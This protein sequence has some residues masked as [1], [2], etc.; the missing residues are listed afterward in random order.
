MVCIEDEPSDLPCQARTAEWDTKQDGF[1]WSLERHLDFGNS[2]AFGMSCTHRSN[3]SMNTILLQHP[4]A[5][6]R[7][8]MYAM[9]MRQAEAFLSGHQAAEKLCKSTNDPSEIQVLCNTIR[10]CRGS[11][12]CTCL[13][14]DHPVPPQTPLH[15]VRWIVVQN[16]GPYFTLTSGDQTWT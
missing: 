3:I 8:Q 14:L 4:G 1:H 16:Y 15:P 13:D 5:E 2:S 9:R 12:E 11:L 10:A 7:K 6:Y